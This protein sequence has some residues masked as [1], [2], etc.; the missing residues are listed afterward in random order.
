MSLSCIAERLIELPGEIAQISRYLVDSRLEIEK[1]ERQ[2]KHWELLRM[3]EISNEVGPDGKALHSNADKRQAALEKAKKESVD[4]S[5]MLKALED[6]R[7]IF[8]NEKIH[9]QS[10]IDSQA[11]YRAIARM[12]DVE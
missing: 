4:L 11:N 1:L 12:G 7:F 2:I 10:L 9:L 5:N 3:E 8:E 6:A